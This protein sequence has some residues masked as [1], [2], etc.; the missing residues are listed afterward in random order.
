MK[1]VIFA[2]LLLAALAVTSQAQE[3]KWWVGGTVG[4]SSTKLPGIHDAS[5]TFTF[6]PELGYNLSDRWAV[7]I[8]FGLNQADLNTDNSSTWF[9]Q[10]SVAPF[11]RYTFWS[12][13]SFSL[14]AD[15]GINFSDLTGDVDLVANKA[16]DTHLTTFGVFIN[17]GFA[18]RLTDRFS[19]IGRTDLFSAD[20]TFIPIS[21]EVNQGTWKT[22]SASLNSPFK[23]DNVEL[24]FVFKF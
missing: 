16:G 22:W 18:V 8:Q 3:K 10:F 21:T 5:E 14:F 12:Y 15:G 7:G 1:K 20:C 17:P 13:K 4:Y 24:G 19:L 9:Q 23:L 2:T 11:A 6:L